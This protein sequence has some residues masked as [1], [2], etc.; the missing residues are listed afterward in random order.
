MKTVSNL[1]SETYYIEGEYG[2][3][4]FKDKT[5]VESVNNIIRV[6]ETQTKPSDHIFTVPYYTPPLYFLTGRTN[7]TYYDS[8][9]DFSFVPE[10]E[11]QEELCKELIA[12][13]VTIVVSSDCM[14]STT[15][16]SGCK[17]IGFDLLQQCIGRNFKLNASYPPYKVYVR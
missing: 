14:D 2:K 17:N 16:M 3:I 13:N 10:K 8:L 6:I 1:R 5:S 12:R 7:P 15:Q 9:L 11:K 4:P